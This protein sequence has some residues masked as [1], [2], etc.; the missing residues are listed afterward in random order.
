M[1]LLELPLQQSP[2]LRPL[3]RPHLVPARHRLPILSQ[4]LSRSLQSV[5][6]SFISGIAVEADTTVAA[7]S[8][9]T[10]SFKPDFFK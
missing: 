9:K 8:Y 4:Q 5:P 3:P 1:R 2:Q 10:K 6:E 7:A